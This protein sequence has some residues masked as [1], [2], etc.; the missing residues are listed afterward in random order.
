MSVVVAVWAT[1]AADVEVVEV[2][3]SEVHVVVTGA[4]CAGV[5]ASDV[6][7]GAYDGST[8]GSCRAKVFAY[9][10]GVASVSVC[11]VR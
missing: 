6:C 1:V 7:F 2:D 5:A 4:L 11:A 3:L 10:E 9:V 8:Y